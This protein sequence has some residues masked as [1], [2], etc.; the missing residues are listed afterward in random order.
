MQTKTIL[1]VL[2][3]V[4]LVALVTTVVS[5]PESANVIR[6]FGDSFSGSI[7]AAMGN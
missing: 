5:R 2:G 6:A 3:A 7:K 4:V 1:D